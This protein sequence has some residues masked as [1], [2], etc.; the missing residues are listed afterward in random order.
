MYWVGCMYTDPNIL[1]DSR[2][3]IRGNN[4]CNNCRNNLY[5]NN[6]RNGGN[7]K[8]GNTDYANCNVGKDNKNSKDHNRNALTMYKVGNRSPSHR[9]NNNRGNNRSRYKYRNETCECVLSK[10]DTH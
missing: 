5:A 4:R 8:D 2:H 7:D 1:N 10:R 9:S 6:R 3:K